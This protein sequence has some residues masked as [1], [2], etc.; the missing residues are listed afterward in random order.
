MRAQVHAHG[1]MERAGGT[2]VDELHGTFCAIAFRPY[3][4]W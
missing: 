4:V 1:Y 3:V 2:R